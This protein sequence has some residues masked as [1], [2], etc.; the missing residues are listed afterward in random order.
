[1]FY[2]SKNNIIST[3]QYGFTAQVSTDSALHSLK[4]FITKAFDKKG[5]CLVISLDIAGA[6]NSCWVPKIL[7]QLKKYNCPKN[8]FYCFRLY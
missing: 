2:M 3:N 7:S 5:F 4:N 8:L 6:F 1:M